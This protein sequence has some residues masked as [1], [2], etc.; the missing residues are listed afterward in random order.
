[1]GRLFVGMAL[2]YPWATKEYLLWSMTI[3]QVF[4]YYNVGMEMRYGKGDAKQD[5]SHAV[6]TAKDMSYEELKAKRDELRR[7]YGAID[8]GK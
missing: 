5:G 1:M 4:Y 8:D 3:G 7:Q 2:L 6:R